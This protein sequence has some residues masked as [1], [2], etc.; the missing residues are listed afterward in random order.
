MKNKL[1]RILS[2][3]LCLV[4]VLSSFTV[5]TFAITDVNG[6][7]MPANAI[8]I[9]NIDE[10]AMI[11]Y[12]Y[13]S[14]GYYYLANDIDMT[15]AT[16]KNGDYY[17]EGLGWEPI[18]NSSTPFTGT[19]N[20][21]GKKLIGL[22]IARGTADNIGLFGYVKNGII[23]NLNLENTNV[24]GNN[25]IAAL[26]GYSDGAS[27][28][29]CFASGI[30]NGTNYAAGVVGYAKNSTIIENTINEC[31]VCIEVN[32][33]QIKGYVAGISSYYDG[34]MN[35]V[36]NR[37]KIMVSEPNNRVYIGGICG[38]G[39]ATIAICANFGIINKSSNN[40]YSQ[41]M[42]VH[43]YIGGICGY[44]TKAIYDASNY[45]ELNVTSGDNLAGGIAGYSNIID[46]AANMGKVNDIC[47]AIA[48]GTGT[49][50]NCF[51]AVAEC[52]LFKP[53]VDRNNPNLM[54]EGYYGK[55]YNCYN[56]KGIICGSGT[57]SNCYYVSDK[58]SV[59]GESRNLR[60]MKLKSTFVDWDF[61]TVWT[62][63]GNE[64]YLYPELQD[65]PMVYTKSLTKISVATEPT[66]LNY[67]EKK[68]ALDVTGG[69]IKLHYDNET[70]ESIPMTPDMISGFDNTAVGAKTLTVTYGDFTT[71]FDVLI[72]A[73]SLSDIEI[74]QKPTKLSYLEVKDTLDVT[75][76]KLKLYYNNDETAEIDMETTM[77]KG[78]DNTAIGPQALTVEYG[79]KTDSFEIEIIE[80]ELIGIEVTKLPTKQSYLEEKETLNLT[81]GKLTLS[82]NN[83]TTQEIDLSKATVT[84]FNNKKVGAQLLTVYYQGFTTTFTVNITQK[85]VSS[86]VVSTLPDTLV[87]LEEKDALDVTGGKI[88]VFYNNSTEEI[89]D[90]ESS[91]VS[92][93]NSKSVGNQILTVTYEGKKAVYEIEVIA[94]K[95]ESISV[96]S[97][98]AKTT[99]REKKDQLNV[100][101]GRITLQYNNE[102][103][104]TIDM[105]AGMVSGFDN[106]KI[107]TQTLTVTYQGKTACFDVEI[108]AKTLV[109][110]S[111]HTKPNK[112]VY[113]E[114]EPLDISGGLITLYYDNDTTDVIDMSSNMVS[115]F[116]ERT[117]GDQTLIVTYLGKS[118]T[119]TVIV[120]SRSVISISISN[121]PEKTEYFE[122]EP[123]DL[124]GGK[125]NVVYNNGDIATIDIAPDMISGYNS[126]NVGEQ[127][128]TVIFGG[129]I[130]TY[131]VTVSHNYSSNIV[132]PT[133][134]E[135][136]YTQY[137]C[138]ICGHHYSK[139]IVAEKG[140]TAGA[141]KTVKEPTTSKTGLKEQR[142]T[143][144]NTLLDSEVIAKK[145]PGV[146]FTDVKKSD[147]YYD[148][149]AWAVEEGVTTGTSKTTFGPNEPCTRAQAVTF[150][151]RAAGCPAPK[152]SNNPFKDVKKSDYFYKAVLWAAEN[153][154]TSGTTKT[155]F[156]PDEICTRGQIVTFLW[157]A[158]GGKK[159]SASNPF[160][161]IKTSDYYYDAVLWA[162]KNN[163][164]TGTS[165]TKFSPTENCTRGQIVTFL[166][167]AIVK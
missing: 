115:G 38:Y 11:G 18:G 136:G 17:N 53:R 123:L 90:L 75:G 28:V 21:N 132:S 161:D 20:G 85:S 4:M 87:Y 82:Y 160:K 143:V 43:S 166:Y 164:T 15:A 114:G 62:M 23:K 10:L 72:L 48:T 84:G 68:E 141:W 74:I 47:A 31:E 155:T 49:Y 39:T 98:P 137:T 122:N 112:V 33:Y 58:T 19:F 109:S 100:T 165:K 55:Y 146:N 36:I 77:I 71:T 27:I 63:E 97:L 9:S 144:C 159:V 131:Q 14:D 102:T 13:P 37:G 42:N 26:C 134:T 40:A 81:G 101:G 103:S 79:G 60:Q 5:S 3:V 57:V 6:E 140:H 147:Y 126:S 45:G 157:R 120:K 65:V 89:I 92:G 163:V 142:C 29:N 50:S 24:C 148:A 34:S 110:I 135:Q 69:S 113:L 32:D 138:S 30:I 116:E 41:Y 96:T 70:T 158:Q 95:L 106:S 150:L 118:T 76:G 128:L 108:I 151:W 152:T 67:L 25:Y 125:L 93:F 51:N 104:E 61:D 56:T 107:G 94:K 162:V 59:N 99:Y 130:V 133:C 22:N 88:T 167:R 7:E 111:V 149:V 117:V 124:S 127:Q 12:E 54:P 35:N 80:K 44:N 73:K 78:F 86:I 46:R 153:N 91:M 8:A 119:I 66:K 64:D 139:D 2:F 83:D 129:K 1:N 156:S 16:S 105:T 154:I 121:M 145:K 52:D